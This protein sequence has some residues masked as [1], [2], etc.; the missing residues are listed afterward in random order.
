MKAHIILIALLF[1]LASCATDTEQPNEQPTA[2]QAPDTTPDTA[3]DNATDDGNVDPSDF[4]P[5]PADPELIVDPS[6][7]EAR[8]GYVPNALTRAEFAGTINRRGPYAVTLYGS[9]SEHDGPYEKS[10]YVSGE[11]LEYRIGDY[12]YI[13]N[14]DGSYLCEFEGS[15]TCEEGSVQ[16]YDEL[17]ASIR[18]DPK[19]FPVKGTGVRAFAGTQGQCYTT[20]IE[21]VDAVLCF[22]E[23]GAPLRVQI[24]RAGFESSFVATNYADEVPESAFKLPGPVN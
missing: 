17:E 20:E 15:W 13:E 5:S 1:V 12:R 18:N 2:D 21:D 11:N 6:E 16:M 9:D 24:T 10:W 22:E 8:E 3:P 23:S 14:E 7:Y 4:E 19:A